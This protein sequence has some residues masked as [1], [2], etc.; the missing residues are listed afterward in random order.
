MRDDYEKFKKAGIQI[1]VVAKDSRKKVK[2]YFQE[3][4]LPYIGIPDPEGKVAG[5]YQ[6]QWKIAKLGLMPA[7]FLIDTGGTISYLHYSSS[8]S[9]IPANKTVLEQAGR[10]SN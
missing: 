4:N 8:M 1:V 3:N 6:Q 7:M 10:L 9:D 5:Q 2:S